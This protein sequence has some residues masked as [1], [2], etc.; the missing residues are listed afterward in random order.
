MTLGE[1]NESQNLGYWN[2]DDDDNDFGPL[3]PYNRNFE[4]NCNIFQNSYNN[5]FS[6]K[7]DGNFQSSHFHAS[8]P[9]PMTFGEGLRMYEHEK[10]ENRYR[11]E[12]HCWEHELNLLFEFDDDFASETFGV[13]EFFEPNEVLVPT[14]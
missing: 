10:I 14:L 8:A 1:Y 4:T 12:D 3:P 2:F 11:E 9:R 13:E 6:F 5:E 7:S